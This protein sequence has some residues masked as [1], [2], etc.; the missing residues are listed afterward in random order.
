VVAAPFQAQRQSFLEFYPR[1][2][3]LLFAFSPQFGLLALALSAIPPPRGCFSSPLRDQV[4]GPGQ[5]KATYLRDCNRHLGKVAFNLPGLEVPSGHVPMPSHPFVGCGG[6]PSRALPLPP[7]NGRGKW[8]KP[9]QL[10][11]SVSPREGVR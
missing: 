4:G 5:L 3:T 10:G 8:N 6:G 7:T 11:V 1:F 2:L 9:R